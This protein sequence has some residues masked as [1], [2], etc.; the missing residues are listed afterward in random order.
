[1]QNKSTGYFASP[2]ASRENLGPNVPNT[3][4]SLQIQVSPHQQL[5]FPPSPKGVDRSSTP[6][7]LSVQ[8]PCKNNS[9]V[10]KTTV[11][12]SHSMPNVSDGHVNGSNRDSL[13]KLH[14]QTSNPGIDVSIQDVSESKYGH[15]QSNRASSYKTQAKG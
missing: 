10:V 2:S 5:S 1:M 11:N 15:E 14:C 12:A 4:M 7:T 6:N 9:D 8:V 3:K 13:H